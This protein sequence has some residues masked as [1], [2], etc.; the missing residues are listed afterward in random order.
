MSRTLCLLL[1]SALLGTA[2]LAAPTPTRPPPPPAP[3]PIVAVPVTYTARLKHVDKAKKVTFIP[4]AEISRDKNGVVTTKMLPTPVLDAYAN[5]L[6]KKWKAYKPGK[7]VKITQTLPTDTGMQPGYV[8]HT[9]E[10]TVGDKLY[11]AAVMYEFLR[12]NGYRAQPLEMVKFVDFDRSAEY[13]PG[14]DDAAS[15]FSNF[16]KGTELEEFQKSFEIEKQIRPNRPPGKGRKSAS[17]KP[18]SLAVDNDDGL[19]AIA[20]VTLKDGGGID[21]TPVYARDTFASNF[22]T[23][24]TKEDVPLDVILP[25]E[26]EKWDNRV[27]P[28]TSPMLLEAYILRYL[29]NAHPYDV[30]PVIDFAKVK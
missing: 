5:D 6:V 13:P 4:V 18:Q 16:R 30:T 12:K 8:P 27:I 25:G 21:V 20:R 1:A 15:T 11:D 29:E 24:S 3:S 7:K 22:G 19:F 17:D 10:F 26:Y 23:F 14:A 28:K 2:A 9:V